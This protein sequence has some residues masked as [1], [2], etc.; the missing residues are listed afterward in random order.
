MNAT[1]AGSARAG[2]NAG[3]KDKP[4]TLFQRLGRPAGIAL[5]IFAVL[6]LGFGVSMLVNS[7]A[8]I[9]SVERRNTRDLALIA[10]N[11]EDRQ[12]D[13]TRVAKL[14]YNPETKEPYVA[15]HPEFGE[16]R[17]AYDCTP[18]PSL[19]LFPMGPRAGDGAQYRISGEF[20]PGADASGDRAGAGPP[21]CFTLLLPLSKVVALAD[22]D[23]D[24][25]NVLI[26][27]ADGTTL[28]QIG[29]ERQP[30]VKLPVL[31]APGLGIDLQKTLASGQA[32]IAA[33]NTVDLAT[34]SGRADLTLNGVSYRAYVQ[35]FRMIVPRG[36]CPFPVVPAP[37]AKSGDAAAGAP[38]AGASA[39]RPAKTST[40]SLSSS[41]PARS[42]GKIEECQLFLVGLMP[43]SAT[44]KAWLAPP[45]VVL[46]GFGMAVLGVI[47]LLP[48]GRLLLISA[49]EA[50]YRAEVLAM[51]L[52][53]LTA[54]AITCLAI[55]FTIETAGERNLAAREGKRV[56]T[57]LAQRIGHEIG[58]LDEALDKCRAGDG[59][60]WTLVID[61]GYVD[62]AGKPIV[63][64]RPAG[65][66]ELR[67]VPQPAT[68]EIGGRGYFK[69]LKDLPDDVDKV[70]IDQIDSQIDGMSKT[71]LLRQEPSGPADASGQPSQARRSDK[72][73]PP[74]AFRTS[75]VLRSLL[76]PGLPP[77]EKLIVV[78]GADSTLPVLFHSEHSRAGIERLAEQIDAPAEIV[79]LLD[80][81]R[82]SDTHRVQ[83]FK[84]RYDGMVSHFVASPIG[85]SNWIL[86]I[87]Y[88]DDDVDLI[89]AKT[90]VRA[91]ACWMSISLIA[92]IVTIVLLAAGGDAWRYLWPF[93]DGAEVYRSGAIHAGALSTI[94]AIA[95]LTTRVH[96]AVVIAAS[97]AMLAW[98]YR[99][100]HRRRLSAAPLTPRTER[101]Y[102]RFA[103]AM[104]ACVA[105]APMAAFWADARALSRIEVDAAREDAAAAIAGKQHKREHGLLEAFKGRPD[106][107][108]W[109]D[110]KPKRDGWP[111]PPTFPSDARGRDDVGFTTDLLTRLTAFAAP[112]ADYCSGRPIRSSSEGR[113]N[114]DRTWFC[115]RAQKGQLQSEEHQHRFEDEDQHQF[116]VA[117]RGWARPSAIDWFFIA[118]FAAA[119]VT[120][121]SV[122]INAGLNALSGFGIPLGAVSWP[123]LV[124]DGNAARANNEQELARK[125]L[126]VAPQKV[127][128]DKL[129]AKP[130]ALLVNLADE[131]LPASDD[132]LKPDGSPPAVP[133][134]W[135]NLS[136]DKRPKRMPPLLVVSG[137]E[138]VLRDA[139][140]RRAALAY[141]ERAVSVLSREPQTELAGLV[142]IAEMAPLERIFDA[143]ESFSESDDKRLSSREELRWARL[144]HDFSTFYF[145][146]IDKVDDAELTVDRD[147][148]NPA[149][150]LDEPSRT[151]IEELRWLPGAVID[152]VIADHTSDKLL[153]VGTT[154]FPLPDRDY[155]EH[156]TFLIRD[157]ARNARAKSKEAAID[158]LRA[159]LIEHYE[160]CWA[161][162]SFSE[163]VI[164]DAIARNS[165]INMRKGVALQ[166]LVRRGLVILDPTPRLMNESFALYLRQSERP[167]TLVKWKAA[168]PRSAWSAARLPLAVVLPLLIV[169]LVMAA[170]ESGQSLDAL[171]PLL[172]AGAPV[173]ISEVVRRTKASGT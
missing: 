13:F 107:L 64:K 134:S 32:Q 87:Y 8:V 130:D 149:I 146:P 43:D 6:A 148:T 57:G 96:P 73:G 137:L 155:Q 98:T 9:G 154:L 173:M 141:L 35:P 80:R 114:G 70:V 59:Q 95:C 135:T 109:F 24:M 145:A 55:L 156:Y 93:E 19:R 83:D 12:S 103:L 31:T 42:N 128:R 78:D 108:P 101:A 91:L 81:L 2:G 99:R 153:K 169:L 41:A 110:A 150:V 111:L 123:K 165:F 94:L 50:V 131:L 129:S 126:L 30:V 163:R 117:P 115:K 172:A 170:S 133:T 120:L 51:L 161:A 21:V 76:A 166:S 136:D 46:V 68:A 5:M 16:V 39:T 84:R 159:N 71:V 162:S 27:A 34:G 151:L 132:A 28:E 121:L 58:R 26:V 142:V 1:E 171:L 48:L 89:A 79:T 125:S 22:L 4:T 52:G 74:F 53:I 77:P 17:I 36:E 75:T 3:P 140:R 40:A 65:K 113:R 139:L 67:C 122:L 62:D 49:T 25:S 37:A 60:Q 102:L 119:L 92:M 97:T 138:L 15:R 45:K 147:P 20:V 157:W 7:Q 118:L 105:V 88:S 18:D 61:A 168:Q 44:R 143:F 116:G 69:R 86:L 164:L 82:S 104:L 90:A 144:F 38:A 11:L 106:L 66:P 47:V 100:L 85:N 29:T 167:D 23:T 72:P 14:K 112:H 56:A 158:Y 10:Q 127:V 160:Q 124:I 54:A 33:P 63:A 152:G